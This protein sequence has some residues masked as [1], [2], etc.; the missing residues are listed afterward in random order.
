MSAKVPL[1]NNSRVQAGPCPPWHTLPL[2]KREAEASYKTPGGR[3]GVKQLREVKDRVRPG[4]DKAGLTLG[5]LPSV[6]LCGPSS[7]NCSS[8]ERGSVG[9]RSLHHPPPRASSPQSPSPTGTGSPAQE[10]DM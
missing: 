1:M 3:G 6:L 8:R 5:P 7:C 9:A 10:R 4:S 2:C